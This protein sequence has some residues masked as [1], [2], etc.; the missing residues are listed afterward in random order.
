MNTESRVKFVGSQSNHRL[1]W[2]KKAKG[3]PPF[4][5]A[6]LLCVRRLK[7]IVRISRNTIRIDV[8]LSC[9]FLEREI[10]HNRISFHLIH[11]CLFNFLVLIL[12][13][14]FL[15]FLM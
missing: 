14:Y 6:Y 9:Q 3:S 11:G 2:G 1:T 12:K 4:A 15:I 10:Y 13:I 5:R 8:S 7:N